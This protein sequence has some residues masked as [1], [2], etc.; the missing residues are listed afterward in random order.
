[1]DHL[2]EG[3]DPG[4]GAAGAGQGHRG[5]D[6]PAERL[7]EKACSGMASCLPSMIS[8]KLRTVSATFTYAPEMPVKTSATWN[9]CDR[10]R[11]TLRARATVVL[12][13]SESSSMP[14]IAMMSCRSLYRCRIF[15][16]PWA[17]S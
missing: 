4:V 5:P 10:K 14:R 13:S 6:D 7:D 16:T 11:C 9:G 17:T 1:M 3:V 12:S 8:L 15:F 2:V